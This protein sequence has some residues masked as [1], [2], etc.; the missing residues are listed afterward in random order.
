[1]IEL[2]DADQAAITDVFTN[3]E[4][5]VNSWTDALYRAGIA[6]GLERAANAIDELLLERAY[7]GQPPATDAE[8]ARM[9]R[10]MVKL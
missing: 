5:T 9:I 7:A 3:K 6:A 4:A 8:C 2:T 1:M 10:I